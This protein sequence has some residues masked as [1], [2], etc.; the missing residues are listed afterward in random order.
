M[1]DTESSDF[2][3]SFGSLNSIGSKTSSSRDNQDYV[4]FDVFFSDSLEEVS[5]AEDDYGKATMIPNSKLSSADHPVLI[6]LENEYQA[7]RSLWHQKSAQYTQEITERISCLHQNNHMSL[8]MPVSGPDSGEKQELLTSSD[9]SHLEAPQEFRSQ[10]KRVAD[11]SSEWWRERQGQYLPVT[12][13]DRMFAQKCRELQCFIKPL[14]KLLNGLKRGRYDRGLSS[15]Q[16]SIAMD[17]IQRIVGVLQKPEMGERYLGTLLQVEFLLKIWF[18]EVIDSSSALLNNDPDEPQN[19]MVKHPDSSCDPTSSCQSRTYPL[20]CC[21]NVSKTTGSS[22]NPPMGSNCLCGKVL[23][24]LPS[25]NLTWMHT[26]PICNPSLSQADLHHLNS[27]LGQNLF[28]PNTNSCGIILFLQNNL[29]S[30]CP[31]PRSTSAMPGEKP[32][33]VTP[34]HSEKMETTLNRPVRSRSV[35]VT[36]SKGPY[37]RDGSH[38]HPQLS[39]CNQRPAG[40]NT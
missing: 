33:P 10:R 18:P 2:Q 21:P 35:P 29:H 7:R 1:D 6:R 12:D 36:L 28:G 40:E 17:R 11:L 5:K 9:E 16:Q 19:K 31:L 37:H 8:D 27:A 15:F 24:E 23:G 39:K 13:G 34:Q 4:D 38:Y 20:P 32:S 25:M 22:P 14:T 3:S 26:A 30:S